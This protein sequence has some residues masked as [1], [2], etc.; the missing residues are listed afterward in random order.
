MTWS[1]LRLLFAFGLA[2]ALGAIPAQAA[3][4]NVDTTADDPALVQCDDATPND[5]SLAPRL[6]FWE[7]HS[8]DLS[9]TPVDV[10][11]RLACSRQLSDAEAAQWR[12]P[13]YV[14]GGWVP[15]DLPERER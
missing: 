15:S 2:A 10:T 1:K 3:V 8:V 7:Y 12:D 5:C 4:F 13:S 11:Q 6:R 9:G 14:L